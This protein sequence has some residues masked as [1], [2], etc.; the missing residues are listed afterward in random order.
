MESGR[1]AGETIIHAK[2]AGDFSE[3]RLAEYRGRLDHSWI[4]ADM[5]KY[6][7]AVPLL[8]HNPQLL[9]KYPQ[10]ADRALDEFFRVD[11]TSKWDK[12][13]KI[14]KMIRREGMFRMGWDTFKAL[15]AM[16]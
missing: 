16:K 4:M 8:E 15:W 10:V 13:K 11:G 1:L 9:T 12:Q 2:E 6:D 14:F 5:R 3:R 7:K